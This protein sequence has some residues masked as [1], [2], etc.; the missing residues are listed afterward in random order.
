MVHSQA[1]TIPAAR[2]RGREVPRLWGG[3]SKPL[4][5]GCL[6]VLQ[7][8][9]SQAILSCE[10]H[11]KQKQCVGFRG[12]CCEPKDTED[13]QREEKVLPGEKEGAEGW[14]KSQG[15]TAFS[16]DRQW[17]PGQHHGEQLQYWFSSKSQGKE[18]DLWPRRLH[19]RASRDCIQLWRQI[20]TVSGM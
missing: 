18:N 19:V 16:W 7:D 1:F 8:A 17:Q 4:Q 12:V 15:T 6:T 14:W 9:S 2:S 10:T 11:W 3:E 5:S 20:A 13:L